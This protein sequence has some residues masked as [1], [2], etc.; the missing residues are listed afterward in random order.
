MISGSAKGDEMGKV[1]L[2]GPATNIVL[3]GAL[4]SLGLTFAQP[5]L[6]WAFYLGAFLNGFMAVFNLIPFGIFDGL[7]VFNWD[8]KVWAVSFGISAALMVIAYVLLGW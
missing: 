4:L 6:S 8:K 3:A 1:S 2:A 5:S 7:K